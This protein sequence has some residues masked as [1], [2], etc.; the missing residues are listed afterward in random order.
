MRPLGIPASVG[1]GAGGDGLANR[2]LD[3][4]PCSEDGGWSRNQEP[5]IG[6][7]RLTTDDCSPSPD[8][9]GG[10]VVRGA[11]RTVTD[12]P[13]V[14]AKDIVLGF[15]SARDMTEAVQLAGDCSMVLGG[16]CVEIRPV[17]TLPGAEA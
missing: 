13:Y 6:N 5:E 16:A 2:I 12:G 15:I 11:E 10:K 3:P 4:R 17:A 1:L 9:R 7:R 14:E 8:H